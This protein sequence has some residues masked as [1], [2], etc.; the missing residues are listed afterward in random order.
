[1][2]THQVPVGLAGE[3]DLADASFALLMD[4]RAHRPEL[5]L[6]AGFLL[7]GADA[8]DGGPELLRILV[9]GVDH[10]GAAREGGFELLRLADDDD[11]L[12]LAGALRLEGGDLGGLFLVRQERPAERLAAELRDLFGEVAAETV[13]FA[14]RDDEGSLE[15]GLQFAHFEARVTE[16][17]QLVAERGDVHRTFL[18][19]GA[20]HRGLA[21]DDVAFAVVEFDAQR[22]AETADDLGVQRPAVVGLL[23]VPGIMQT[24]VEF[25]VLGLPQ[26]RAGLHQRPV[27][28]FAAEADERQAA[29]GGLESVDETTLLAFG[30]LALVEDYAVAGLERAF[31][32]HRH[33][34]RGDVNDR[35]EVGAALLPEAGVDELLIVDAAE[36]ARMQAARERHLHRVVF[37]LTDLERGTV[38][39]GAL[40]EGIP[41]GVHRA[42]VGLRDGRHVF[43]GFETSFDL[44]RT[45]AGADQVGH[46]FDAGE[47][48]RGEE[49][50]LVAE[51]AAHAVDHEFVGQAAGLGAFAAIGRAA[52]ER[53]ARQA[54]AGIGDA[55]RAVHEDLEVEG[56]ALG[57]LFRLHLLHL[58]DR[59]LTAEDGERGAETAGV[60]DARR[61]RHRH[62]GRGMNRE[63]GRDAAD[64]AADAG[65]LDDGGVDARRDDRAERA[66]GLGEFVGEDQ[67]VEGH[68]ALHAATV[69]IGHQFRQVSLFEVLGPHA[70]VEAADAEEHRVG[71]VLDRRADAVPFAGRG[72]DFGLTEGGEEA[73]GGHGDR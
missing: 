30:R 69:Q 22:L 40:D 33:A 50:G 29:A 20:R 51:I 35:A 12:G 47:V 71:A 52:A 53:F 44:E 63:V 39:I 62:L 59:D 10:A 66:C 18:G 42:T 72:E 3:H 17:T 65:V 21:G 28:V 64:E 56:G 67:R 24:L 61:A 46:D 8:R 43:G 26:D 2:I 68:V 15:I 14:D 60:I 1:M 7:I 58:R 23:A 48:L 16:A 11:D 55:E 34:V 31:E 6:A 54:L 45:D 13:Q 57:G 37:L 36:P 70:G 4:T 32:A 38:G 25:L 49:V 19:R 27:D 73:G 5:D 9:L 41:G